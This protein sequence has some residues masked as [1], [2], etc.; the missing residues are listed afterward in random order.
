LGLTL[1]SLGWTQRQSVAAFLYQSIVGSVSAALKLLPMGQL[2]GQ[3][4]IEWALPVIH[5]LSEQVSGEQVMTAWT[6]VHDIHA[7]RHGQLESRL[8]RS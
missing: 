7:M 5:E 2:A 1:G 4:L 6:P 3:D 8:F